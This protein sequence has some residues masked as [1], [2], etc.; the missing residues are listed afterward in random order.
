[1]GSIIKLMKWLMIV[2]LTN[3]M[4]QSCRKITYTTVDEPAYLRVFNSLNHNI[5][6]DSKDDTAAFLC[7]LINPEYDANGIPQGAEIVGDFLDRRD[8]YAPPYPSHIGV[9][10]TLNNPEYP[11]KENVPVGPILNGFDL[12]SWAKIP[13]GAMRVVF[14][15][16]PKNE[17]PFFNLESQ[18]K[19]NKLA[20]TTINFISGEVYTLHVLMKDFATRSKG[21][22]LRTENFHKQSLSDSEVY[23]NFY[24]YSARGYLQAFDKLKIPTGKMRTNLFEQGVRDTLNV[25]LKLFKGQDFYRY[26]DGIFLQ[27]ASLASPEYENKFLATVVRDVSSGR[28]KP[29]SSFP[30][31]VS[32]AENGIATDLWQRFYFLRPGLNLKQSLFQEDGAYYDSGAIITS[33]GAGLYGGVLDEVDGNFASVNCLL[34]G[35]KIYTN[36]CPFCMFPN[37]H[38]G[39]NFPN[40]VVSTHSG[41]YN[42]KSFATVNTFEIINGEVYLTTIQRRYAAPSY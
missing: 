15:Y 19:K 6:M 18:F 23:V 1:M 2:I 17:V 11:G 5:L 12:S 32:T 16:R 35:P 41:V 42:P 7:M 13:S 9:S 30:L 27:N 34:N 37:Y 40:L 4:F 14:F 39:I 24:N 36:S 10:T 33:E 31:W 22:L 26:S 21:L 25:Y 28:A 8:Y 20:D 3:F 38:A 29:Y